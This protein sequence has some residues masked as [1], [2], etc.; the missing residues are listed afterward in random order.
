MRMH[1]GSTH[2]HGLDHV[3]IASAY[4]RKAELLAFKYIYIY[5]QICSYGLLRHMMRAYAVGGHVCAMD[6]SYPE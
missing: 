5:Y 2:E 4:R 6:R 3:V 1:T